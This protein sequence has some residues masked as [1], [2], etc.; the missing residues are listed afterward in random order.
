MISEDAAGEDLLA[1]L[2]AHRYSRI[3]VFREE[4][5]HV[6]GVLNVIDVVLVE[7]EPPPVSEIM[8]EPFRL[9]Q[10]MPVAEA[11]RRMREERQPLAVVVDETGDAVGL[12]TIKDLVEEI[13]GELRA[14]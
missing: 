9:A 12:A 13:V 5:S 11:L 2:R 3:P 4:R 6:V 7:G 14:W 10:T 1:L 8:R